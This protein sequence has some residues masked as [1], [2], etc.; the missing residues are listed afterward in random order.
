LVKTTGDGFLV[1]FGSPVEAVRCAVE[2]QEATSANGASDLLLRMGINLGDIIV[3]P[4]GDIYGEGV[5]LAARLEQLA[6]PGSIWLS[7][8]VHRHVSGKIDRS[9]HDC[10]EQQVKNIARPL[11]VYAISDAT[12]PVRQ[13]KPL[14]LPD[15]PSIAV[16]PFTN[17]SGDPDNEYFVDGI[18]E[19]II[20]ALSRV[21]WFFVIARN[22]SFTYKG[23]AVDLR[24]VGRELGVRYVL[25]GSVRKAGDKVRITG[26]LIEAATGSHLWA[27][28]FDGNLSN[29]FNLQDEITE[30]IVAAIEP[31]LR[32]VEIERAR[33]KP[34]ESLDAYDLYL[35]ALP[36]FHSYTEAGFRNAESLLCR[37][38]AKDGSFAEAW[39]ALADC[40][41]RLVVAGWIVDAE[42]GAEAACKAAMR[43]VSADPENGTVLAVA[44]WSLA[45]L[46][47]RHDQA[48]DLALRALRLH[49]NSAYVRTCCGWA[50]IFSGNPEHA[51]DHFD[52]ARR[53]SPVDPRGYLTLTAIGAAHFFQKQFDQTVKWASHALE[54]QPRAVVPL[55]YR[56]AALAHLGRVQQGQAD[57]ARLLSVQPNS[58]LTRTDMFKFRHRWMLDLLL[59]GLRKAGL[60]E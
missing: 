58:T 52:V 21:R 3:E 57:I 40:L 56:A 26:Q 19:D 9:F 53:L 18:V 12:R 10:G 24:Q 39:A 25:E 1:E 17:M 51:L 33:A 35:R 7:E 34:T 48:H 30:Q 6:E 60:P 5:N 44:A 55:R 32:L 27:D 14:A 49:P 54:E 42:Q 38:V 31:S 15:K 46:G 22:S 37:A 23:R 43:G 16:L 28:R 41:A 11:R 59:A 2:I 45:M 8:E 50:L 29:I 13:P 4:D 20:T 36:E 47:G